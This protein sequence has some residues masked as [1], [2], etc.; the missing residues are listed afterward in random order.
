MLGAQGAAY[1]VLLTA[2]TVWGLAYWQCVR[3]KLDL[4]FVGG[5]ALPAA[6]ALGALAVVEVTAPTQWMLRAVFTWM[7]YS[8]I[9]IAA[10]RHFF[11][12]SGISPTRKRMS[13]KYSTRAKGGRPGRHCVRED[14]SMGVGY[15]GA[16]V[17]FLLP[18]GLAF[19]LIF[20]QRHRAKATKV[21]G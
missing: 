7:L 8:I 6:A 2:A 15:N 1:G 16:R 12:T 18:L 14:W 13:A 19:L 11:Q 5:T 21:G 10:D 9:V 4:P 20:L 3:H 17:A